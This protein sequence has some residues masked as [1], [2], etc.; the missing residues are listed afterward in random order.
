[1]TR[2]RARDA[3]T[4]N[5]AGSSGTTASSPNARKRPRDEPLAGLVPVIV[6]ELSARLHRLHGS[7]LLAAAACPPTPA[8]AVDLA[9]ALFGLQAQDA[10]AAALALWNRLGGPFGAPV[11]SA[12]QIL[13]WFGPDAGATGLVR[14][15][16]QRGT[17]HV[18]DRWTW[19]VVC[20]FA[21]E[22]LLRQRRKSAGAEA[23]RNAHDLLRKKLEA[24]L[25]VGSGD[26]PGADSSLRY[27]TFMSLTLDGLGSRMDCVGGT[28]IAPRAHVAPDMQTWNPPEEGHAVRQAARAYFS[29]FGPATELDFRYYMGLTAT[30]SRAAVEGLRTSG[31]LLEVQISPCISFRGDT[32]AALTGMESP[33]LITPEALVKLLELEKVSASLV[34]KLPVLLL[35]RF[36]VL[37]LGH[38]DKDWLLDPAIKRHVW[39]STNMDIKSVLLLR[40]RVCGVW[41]PL[42]NRKRSLTIKV[43]LFDGIRLAGDERCELDLRVANIAK[44]FFGADTWEVSIVSIQ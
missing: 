42:W 16:G 29:S 23:L 5:A 31:E 41:R 44:G 26:L 8:G 22:R 14:C 30:P 17:I 27:S 25:N 13:A 7:R 39:S 24:G 33:S 1:M 9:R 2:K 28:V 10:N 12:A 11:P 37:L 35:G 18:Y 19:P 40:G 34:S 21:R 6:S 43:E 36:D 4:S 20:A 32:H 15:H 3:A 38:Q